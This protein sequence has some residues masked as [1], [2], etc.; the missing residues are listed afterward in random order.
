[1]VEVPSPSLLAAAEDVVASGISLPHALE[2]FGELQRHSR[3]A[4]EKLVKLF[5]E[6]VWTPFSDAGRPDE[7]WEDL[8][9]AMNKLRPIAAEALLV[10]F[11]RA[12]SDEVEAAFS[13]IA[14]RLARGKR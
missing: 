2:M 1:M 12:L 9:E 14:K 8:A 3:I 6:D 7:Q 4:S 10:I 13:D 11:R 5:L